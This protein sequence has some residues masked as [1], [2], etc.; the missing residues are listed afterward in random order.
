VAAAS[1][2]ALGGFKFV[3]QEP[4]GPYFADFVCP[5]EGLIVDPRTAILRDSHISDR[6]EPEMA[7]RVGNPFSLREKVARSAG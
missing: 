7:L 1:G 6:E 4:I 3:R 5:D 2:R